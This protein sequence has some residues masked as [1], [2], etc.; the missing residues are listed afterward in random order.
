M[1]RQL[2]PVLLVVLWSASSAQVSDGDILFDFTVTDIEGN[3]HALY[4][5]LNEGKTVVIFCFAAWDSYAWEIYQQQ[6]LETFHAIHGQGGSQVCEVWRFESES[7]NGLAQ[8]S[9]PESIDGNTA[10]DTYGNWIANSSV[11]LIDTSFFAEQVALNYLPFVAIVCP[12]RVVRFSQATAFY[13]LEEAVFE[14]SCQPLSEG[15]DPALFAPVIDRSC[16]SDSVDVGFV[17]KNLGTDTLTSVQ[18]Q[19]SGAVLPE[20]ITWTGN[21]PAYASDTIVR[22]GLA[23]ISDDP[24]LIAVAQ[25][26]V[27][28]T[29]DSLG[30]RSE[31][32]YSQQLVKLE[33]ALDNYPAEVSWEIR[34]DIDS[35][36]FSGGGYTIPY[37]YISGYFLL[38]ESGCYSFYL[39]DAVGDGLHGSQYGGFDGFCK[40]LSMY[41]SLNADVALFDYDGSYNFTNV[42]NTPSFVQIP[43]ETGSGL[44][45]D[46]DSDMGMF[47]YPNPAHDRL[48]I[49]LQ[50]HVNY[51]ALYISNAA[52]ILIHEQMLGSSDQVVE[53]ATDALPA[54]LYLATL[55]GRGTTQRFTFLIHHP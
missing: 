34:N 24:L 19:L 16:G 27:N 7:T 33:L 9:G 45:V 15:F 20:I 4:P 32:G 21:L 18:L 52:G 2:L 43:F 35:I 17:I 36:L 49:R 22:S 1:F 5:T 29:N 6:T 44:N 14:N 25:S 39:R 40:L 10:T 55:R 41:D 48:T 50:P 38:P 13:A 46:S 26:N 23:L 8:L 51:D 42:P 11:P 31:V 53:L 30:V 54:G 28:T 37:Q 12:D 47:S 3:S